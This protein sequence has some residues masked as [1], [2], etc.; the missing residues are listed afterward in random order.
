ML[1][2]YNHWMLDLY[3]ISKNDTMKTQMSCCRKHGKNYICLRPINMCVR[4]NII[5]VCTSLRFPSTT[6]D[7][8]HKNGKNN[9]IYLV[10]STFEAHHLVLRISNK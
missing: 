6:K 10:P 2:R 1:L 8:R 9:Y 4:K 7:K 5:S 3:N